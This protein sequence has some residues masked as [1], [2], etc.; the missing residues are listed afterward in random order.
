MFE[1][2]V[3]FHQVH[4]YS[5]AAVHLQNFIFQMETLY[6]LSDIP[7]SLLSQPLAVP[8]PAFCLSEFDLSI[9]TSFK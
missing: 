5:C 4:P 6:P 2:T 8:H 1:C 9:D 7:H 3:E